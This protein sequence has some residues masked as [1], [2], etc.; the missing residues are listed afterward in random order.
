MPT[1]PSHNIGTEQPNDPLWQLEYDLNGALRVQGALRAVSNILQ[2]WKSGEEV[3]VN[4]VSRE[5]LASL[6]EVLADK[7]DERLQAATGSMLAIQGFHR[8]TCEVTERARRAPG[9]PGEAKGTK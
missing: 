3:D 9:H 8:V 6:F 5:D 2:P 7:L 1:A 4:N